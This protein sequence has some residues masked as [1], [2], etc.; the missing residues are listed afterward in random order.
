MMGIWTGVDPYS[1]PLS[2]SQDTHSGESRIQVTHLRASDALAKLHP[3]SH[4]LPLPF[5]SRGEPAGPLALTPVLPLQ[6]G[7]SPSLG[8]LSRTANISR[9][10]SHQ[11]HVDRQAPR[12]SPTPGT[13]L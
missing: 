1:T 4:P 9:R 12:S 3:Y 5:L 2:H 7:P 10:W 8:T 6:T 13:L 11:Y